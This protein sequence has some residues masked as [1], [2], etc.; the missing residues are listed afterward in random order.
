MLFSVTACIH[1]PDAFFTSPLDFYVHVHLMVTRFLCTCTSHGH[2]IFVY[3]YISWYP[4]ANELC[5]FGATV[6][7]LKRCCERLAALCILLANQTASLIK[8]ISSICLWKR[9]FLLFFEFGFVILILIASFLK[10]YS[11][12]PRIAVV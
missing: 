6:P 4:K 3:M 10:L 2:S 9:P 5:I 1:Q 7:F 12:G 11:L 8:M